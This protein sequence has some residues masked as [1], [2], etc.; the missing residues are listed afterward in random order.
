[1]PRIRADY[2]PIDIEAPDPNTP[3]VD[4]LNTESE[5]APSSPT[6]T[7]R[8]SISRRIEQSEEA[9]SLIA[10]NL[11]QL[12]ANLIRLANG[13]FDRRE[14]RWEPAAIVTVEDTLRTPDGQTMFDVQG[15]P[16]RIRRPAFP[17]IVPTEFVIVERRQ[18]RAEPDRAANEYLIDRVMGKPTNVQEISDTTTNTSLRNESMA[19]LANL[20]PTELAA[21]IHAKLQGQEYEG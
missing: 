15:K 13:G 2:Q 9:R 4:S 14:E 17:D 19:A 1:M 3:S 20:D 16:I 10:D 18:L 21:R 6:K 11:P 12:V 5:G 8:Q 7:K